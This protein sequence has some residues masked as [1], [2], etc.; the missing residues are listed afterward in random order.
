[1]LGRAKQGKT[2]R[3]REIM[4]HLAG[5]P[6]RFVQA[7]GE[8]GLVMVCFTLPSFDVVFKV[9]FAELDNPSSQY[10]KWRLERRGLK[11]PVA[12]VFDVDKHVPGGLDLAY[13]IDVI[14]HVDDPWG[15]LAGLEERA[16]IVA[17]NF[18]E[19]AHDHNHRNPHH[20]LP[21]EALLEHCESRGI[22]TQRTYHE[23]RSHFVIYRSGG[24]SSSPIGDR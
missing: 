21:I 23:G 19:D 16:P 15:F 2:E 20:T 6:D 10:L 17:V 8:R 11:A 22:I 7:A 5:T 4:R 9:G 24:P 18:L 3:Y 13:S 12:E 14:E 1:M